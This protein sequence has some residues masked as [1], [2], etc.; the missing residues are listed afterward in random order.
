MVYIDKS[1]NITKSKY[2]IKEPIFVLTKPDGT[3]IDNFDTEE[4]A[5]AFA[6]Y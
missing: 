5:R 6:E 3:W 4:S 2:D 1:T